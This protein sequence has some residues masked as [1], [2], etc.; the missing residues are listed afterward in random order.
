MLMTKWTSF[1]STQKMFGQNDNLDSFF[2]HVFL[3]YLYLLLSNKESGF[4]FILL[5]IFNIVICFTTLETCHF[6]PAARTSTWCHLWWADAPQFG[7]TVNVPLL[8]QVYDL[9]TI[10]VIDNVIA[11]GEPVNLLTPKIWLLILPS[12]C[13]TFPCKLVMRTWC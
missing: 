13:Y 8:L 5:L 1:I 9:P 4:F 3:Y 12:G 2:E 10:L 7:A 6:F 11:A